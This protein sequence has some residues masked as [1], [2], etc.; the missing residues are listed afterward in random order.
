MFARIIRRA[1]FVAVTCIGAQGATESLAQ[2]ADYT[3]NPAQG[4]KEEA[5]P[6]HEIEGIELTRSQS[7]ITTSLEQR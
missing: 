4:C 6:S 2:M 1:A 7:A 5:G 3:C